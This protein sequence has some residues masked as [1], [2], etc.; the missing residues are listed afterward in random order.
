ML[1]KNP[2]VIL[3]GIAITLF[4]TR[5]FSAKMPLQRVD[6][7]SLLKISVSTS[8]TGFNGSLT[9]MGKHRR[10]GIKKVYLSLT[11]KFYT[12]KN[13]FYERTIFSHAFI[14]ALFSLY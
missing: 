2:K 5:N 13:Q 3:A 7:I 1:K 12:R 4:D 9:S 14:K 10:L 11:L 6:N 8:I